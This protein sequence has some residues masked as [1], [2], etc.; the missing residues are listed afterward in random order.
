MFSFT[1]RLTGVIS[2][3]YQHIGLLPDWIFIL[4]YFTLINHNYR[5]FDI[6]ITTNKRR[7]NT[8]EDTETNINIPTLSIDNDNL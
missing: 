1:F 2:L 6:T 7:R 5:V 4:D 3:L 8:K